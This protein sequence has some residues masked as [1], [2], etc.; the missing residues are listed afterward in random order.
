MTG[1]NPGKHNIFDFF[2]IAPN[3]SKEIT[4]SADRKS[5]PLWRILES[6]GKRSIVVNLPNT[7]PA[8]DFDG[9]MVAGMPL[10]RRDEGFVTPAALRDEV[11]EV[12]DNKF[13]GISHT[14]LLQGDV[15]KFLKD[16]EEVTVRITKLTRHLMQTRD[17][18]CTVVIY[19]DLDRLQHV[20]WHHMD[21]DHPFHDSQTSNPYQDVLLNYYRYIEAQIEELLNGLDDD[22]LLLV[23]SDH[24][25]GPVYKNLHVNTF[26]ERQ[27][28]LKT[29]T[30]RP[31]LKEFLE[32][33]GVSFEDIR[34]VMG[35]L[36]LRRVL[37]RLVPVQVKRFLR[38][39]LPAEGVDLEIINWSRTL[40]W[41]NSKAYLCSKTG[42]AVMINRANVDD[43]E[44]FRDEIIAG[45]EA[46]RDPETGEPVVRK[47]HRREDIYS[48]P[49]AK[50]AP[51]LVVEEHKVYQVQEKIGES[52]VAPLQRGRVPIAAN[53]QPQGL[54]TLSGAGIDHGR[55]LSGV[56]IMDI[57]PT[58][59]YGMGLP[60]PEEMDGNP[61]RDAFSEA[62]QAAHTDSHSAM[63]LGEEKGH[64]LSESD[65][66]KIQTRLRDLG[67]VD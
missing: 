60:I 21:P 3:H 46:L 39:C 50:N 24:G 19:D 8:D 47:V 48:G 65:R 33:I 18:D 15:D 29:K 49:Y 56:N 1:T 2:R 17:W 61:A 11:L 36:G 25:M 67:Y 45:L 31:G 9:V 7:F 26:F 30:P 40:D 16:L 53:H 14:H 35:K 59:L 10:P 64:G 37:R 44:A 42:H 5:K 20:F 41:D 13:L 28:W 43:Y 38:Q 4:S 57:A 27:G 66:D 55:R 22:I 54:F 51:D 62:F 52:I 6:Y 34:I 12:I 58:L 63:A 32:R 23:Y